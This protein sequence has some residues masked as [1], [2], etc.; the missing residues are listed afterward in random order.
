MVSKT[1][2]VGT[3][4]VVHELS[5][6]YWKVTFDNGP[7][8]LFDVES[9]EELGR[10]VTRIEESPELNCVPPSPSRGSEL[11]RCPVPDKTDRGRRTA[12]SL[13]RCRGPGTT[14]RRGIGR[15]RTFGRWT[16]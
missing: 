16:S 13:V 9:I 8:N 2:G 3:Q 15:G 12:P 7:V 4:F 11:R 5:P 14:F 1:V 6:A 10:L